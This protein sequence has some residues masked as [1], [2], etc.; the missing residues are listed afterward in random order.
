M[1]PIART[2]RRTAPLLAALLLAA[3]CGGEAP[4]G[5]SAPEEAETL[6]PTAQAGDTTPYE[7][8]VPEGPG[9]A[10]AVLVDN[11]GSMYDPAPGDT[12]PKHEVARQAVAE[13]LRL[14]GAHAAREPGLPVKVGIWRFSGDA[15]ALMPMQPYHPDSVDAALARMGEPRGGTAIGDAM[16]RAREEL[17]RAGTFRKYLLV[18]TD[19]ENNEGVP[20]QTVARQIRDRS[21]GGVRMF[22]VAF[23]VDPARFAFVTDAGG[24]LAAADDG[25]AL[26]RTLEQLYA[27][28]IL[29]EAA[30]TG[31]GAPAAGTDTAPT[32]STQP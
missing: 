8:Q 24:T 29:A 6:D 20:P 5:G 31:E 1:S 12:R 32:E 17:Y 4:G 7:P 10:V 27:G 11:S 14:T 25:E 26:G 22:F 15:E 30:D 16:H 23:D 18:I 28:K 21:E 13:M 9:V 3:A 19:G 2:R